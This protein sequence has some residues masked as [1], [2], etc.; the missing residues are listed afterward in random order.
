MKAKY[1]TFLLHWQTKGKYFFLCLQYLG[2]GGSW[3]DSCTKRFFLLSIQWGYI[4]FSK[5]R[6]FS[7]IILSWYEVIFNE[8]FGSNLMQYYLVDTTNEK[9]MLLVHASLTK[10]NIMHCLIQKRKKTVIVSIVW[11]FISIDYFLS[12]DKKI[13]NNIFISVVSHTN[14]SY[15][16]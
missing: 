11:P 7:C 12:I 4:A 15:K 8:H 16:N 3:K 10:N 5:P 6:C 1:C 9:V 13:N 2:F 14:A